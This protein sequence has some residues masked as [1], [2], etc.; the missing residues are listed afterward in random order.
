MPPPFALLHQRLQKQKWLRTSVT[1]LMTHNTESFVKSTLL[2]VRMN[3]KKCK[4][5][6]QRFEGIGND[7][8]AYVQSWK[9]FPARK[10]PFSYSLLPNSHHSHYMLTVRSPKELYFFLW[11]TSIYAPTLKH[12]FF[13]N[14]LRMLSIGSC[15][16]SSFKHLTARSLLFSGRC[17]NANPHASTASLSHRTASLQH[18]HD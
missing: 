12:N 16:I 18:C 7:P 5:I 8:N 14:T 1:W 4:N 17:S 6:L 3:N 15:L 11:A 13:I 2:R 10:K 9:P